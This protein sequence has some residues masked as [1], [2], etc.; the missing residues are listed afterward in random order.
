MS[1]ML[2]IRISFEKAGSIEYSFSFNPLVYSGCQKN[3]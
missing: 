3:V 2:K 1:M